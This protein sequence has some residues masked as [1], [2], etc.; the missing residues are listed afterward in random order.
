MVD[1]FDNPV[2]GYHALKSRAE[3]RP[4]HTRDFM[5]ALK[6]TEGTFIRIDLSCVTS[7]RVPFAGAGERT[8]A[9]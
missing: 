7:P 6:E 3:N 8:P 4:L 1:D 2:E 5:D 9:P